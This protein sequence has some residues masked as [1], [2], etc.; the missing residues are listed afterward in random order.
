MPPIKVQYPEVE[1]PEANQNTLSGQVIGNGLVLA[2]P[3]KERGGDKR[4]VVKLRLS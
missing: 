1:M 2:F 4:N 3:G